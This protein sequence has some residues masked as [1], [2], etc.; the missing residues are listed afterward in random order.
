VWGVLALWCASRLTEPADHRPPV[1]VLGSLV[2]LSG[3]MTVVN[4]YGLGLWR[5]LAETVR[6][7]RVEIQ[8][9]QPL[10]RDTPSSWIL[11][12]CG[13]TYAAYVVRRY[14]RP[15]TRTATVVTAFAGASLLVNRLVPLFVPATV[16]LLAPTLERGDE[17]SSAVPLQRTLFDVAVT[18]T[19][20]MLVV[21]STVLNGCIDVS[22]DWV[23]DAQAARALRDSGARGRLIT[24]FNWG[25]Y[26]LWHLSPNLKISFDGRR[27]TVYSQET[28][29][30][31]LSIAGGG[32]SGL[33]A[34][35][36]LSPEYVWLPNRY[37]QATKR[38]LQSHRYRVDIDTPASFVAAREGLPPVR[39]VEGVQSGCFP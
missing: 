4:P 36:R 10:W 13:V 19:V 16:V 38:W 6:L 5:F 21:H 11:W 34:L 8:E 3:L 23:A 22:G 20:S 29:R 39:A 27:E 15:P 30:E 25:E 32:V 2:V 7:S 18:I 9:W 12:T 14:G 31:Q 26:A 33:A 28:I 17:A 37:S 24:W 1:W 35:E